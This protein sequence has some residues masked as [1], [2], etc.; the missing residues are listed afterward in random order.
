M[1]AIVG[2]VHKKQVWLG[3][4]SAGVSGYHLRVRTDEK[5]F[6]NG[7][8]IFGF[9]TSFR[10]G[11]LLRFAFKPPE[12]DDRIDVRKYMATTFV[13]SVR[14][15]L[16]D[17]GF[18]KTDS[19]REEGGAFLVGYQSHLFEI[20]DDFQVAENTDGIAA[21][22]CGREAALG[23]LWAARALPGKRRVEIALQA[24]ERFSAGVRAPFHVIS[25]NP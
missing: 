18:A 17:G 15:C 6:R 25:T 1:T 3:G 21:V 13:N 8:F 12:H 20:C 14:Q 19:G 10:M 24:A 11:Q 16:K 23:A 5:V 7:P 9:T 22:G 4:D 2:V